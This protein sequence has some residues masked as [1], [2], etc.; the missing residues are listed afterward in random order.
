[1]KIECNNNYLMLR[2]IHCFI[3]QIAHTANHCTQICYV[4]LDLQGRIGI[5]TLHLTR[6]PSVECHCSCKI[7]KPWMI[8]EPK[9]GWIHRNLML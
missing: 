1:M 2:M 3:L 9:A 8:D 4:G 6:K 5:P 7:L